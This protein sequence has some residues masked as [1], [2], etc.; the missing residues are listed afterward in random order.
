MAQQ[1]LLLSATCVALG[2]LA[3]V[4]SFTRGPGRRPLEALADG[5]RA[6][7]RKVLR[8]V[9]GRRHS[10]DQSRFGDGTTGVGAQVDLRIT[11][12][13]SLDL[14][15]SGGYALAFEEGRG[16]RPEGMVSLKLLK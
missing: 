10:Q 3:A 9:R 6:L 12:L 16:V 5:L 14:T 4:D 1:L 15:L 13:S 2:V 7:A 11:I 8:L